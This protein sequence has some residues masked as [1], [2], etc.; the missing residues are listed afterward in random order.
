MQAMKMSLS[1]AIEAGR[2]LEEQ[3]KS[4][5]H[6]LFLAWIDTFMPFS[7][8]AAERYMS[9][10]RYRDKFDRVSNLQ[11]AYKQ[12]EY[13]KNNEQ[14]E[15]EKEQD[16]MI[17]QRVETGEKPEGWN[18]S[19]ERR[20]KQQQEDKDYEERKREAFKPKKQKDPQKDESDFE[21]LHEKLNNYIEN[22]S[23]DGGLKLDSYD[24]EKIQEHFFV[25]MENYVSQFS[26]IQRQLEV[27]QNL[28]KKLRKM[29][30]ECQKAIASKH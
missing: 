27:I 9:L 10:Y 28:I 24:E 11:E 3:K 15:Q 20:F 29:G 7:D 30:V 8:K 6:G 23:Q 18:R 26:N 25:S 16:Q 1:N 5:K 22:N 13:V 17:K 19:I 2:L 12:I 21:E 4:L 14:Q